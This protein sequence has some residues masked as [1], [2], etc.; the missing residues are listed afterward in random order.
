MIQSL[1]G[2]A[3]AKAIIGIFQSWLSAINLRKQGAAEQRARTLNKVAMARERADEAAGKINSVSDATDTA[4]RRVR[5][6]RKRR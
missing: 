1:L 3:I 6:R 2:S 4:L 5:N